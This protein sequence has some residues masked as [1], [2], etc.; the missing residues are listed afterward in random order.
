MARNE[1]R[2]ARKRN[3]HEPPNGDDCK[4]PWLADDRPRFW[5]VR[6]SPEWFHLSSYNASLVKDAR[7]FTG[8]WADG[9][10][11]EETFVIGTTQSRKYAPI[12]TQTRT[13]KFLRVGFGPTSGLLILIAKV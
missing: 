11:P 12:A 7:W 1:T 5:N 13:L 3:E 2:S 6:A 8:G 9:T 10:Y 4:G